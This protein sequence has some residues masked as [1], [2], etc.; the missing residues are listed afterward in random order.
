MD[1]ITTIEGTKTGPGDRPVEP[2]TVT[3]IVITED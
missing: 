1:V 2:V 3:T